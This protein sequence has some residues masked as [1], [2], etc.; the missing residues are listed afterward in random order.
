MKATIIC[1]ICQKP[2]KNLNLHKYSAHPETR[3]GK[4]EPP[5]PQGKK[6]PP[7]PQ[8]PTPK[9]LEIAKTVPISPDQ[10]YHCMDC[11]TPFS[12]GEPNCPGCGAKLDWGAL[13]EENA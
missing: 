12:K 11:G 1:E 10:S 2:V 13:N 9:T 8:P 3:Q 6:E 7:A 4:K 5:A